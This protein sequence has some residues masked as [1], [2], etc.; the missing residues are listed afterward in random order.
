MAVCISVNIMHS[1]TL[2]VHPAAPPLHD[3]KRSDEQSRRVELGTR[4]PCRASA[5]CCAV[6]CKIQITSL[7]SQEFT[8]PLPHCMA[9]SEVVEI[10]YV[11]G[12]ESSP[13]APAAQDDAASATAW[14]CAKGSKLLTLNS[15]DFT[16][17]PPAAQDH[18]ASAGNTARLRVKGSDTTH[19]DGQEFTLALPA[20]QYDG[21]ASH[22]RPHQVLR[23]LL[24]GGDL[25]SA[26]PGHDR[27]GACRQLHGVPC[28]G[29]RA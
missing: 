29:S 27:H 19:L 6:L 11:G 17:P 20:V 14:L 1:Y 3:S 28:Q 10:L 23:H 21:Q 9:P 18:A 26:A 7:D 13:G 16:L 4:D 2:R 12:Q 24:Q 25:A 15:Q 8:L 22:V 5:L